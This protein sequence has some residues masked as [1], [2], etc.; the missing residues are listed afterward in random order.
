MYISVDKNP[1]EHILI[2][3]NPSITERH[4]LFRCFGKWAELLLIA[5]RQNVKKPLDK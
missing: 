3:H 5:G 4:S 1:Q 2:L